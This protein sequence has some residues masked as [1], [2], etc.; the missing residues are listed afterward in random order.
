MNIKHWI[1]SA[2]AIGVGAY[3][4]PGV[5]VTFIGAFVLAIV[6]GIINIFIRPVVSLLT[7]PLTIVTLGLFTLV[8]NAGFIVLAAMIVPGFSV[9]SFWSALLFAIALTV[10]NTLFSVWDKR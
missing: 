10:I 5:S 3:I 8:I 6:L 1:V 4:I 9:S 7:L 2:I